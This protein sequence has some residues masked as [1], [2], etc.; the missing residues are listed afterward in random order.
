MI[1]GMPPTREEMIRSTTKGRIKTER[2]MAF[3]ED[4]ARPAGAI[5]PL[6]FRTTMDRQIIDANG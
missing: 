2:R 5:G 3:P 1:G 6:A 4:Q